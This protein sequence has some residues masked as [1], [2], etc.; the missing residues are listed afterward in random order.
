MIASVE[1]FFSVLAMGSFFL[2]LLNFIA[3]GTDDIIGLGL[4][5]SARSSVSQNECKRMHGHASDACDFIH[6][7]IVS[8]GPLFYCPYESFL[9]VDVELKFFSRTCWVANNVYW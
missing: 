1:T 8:F 3:Y 7:M 6:K 9:R 5:P 2:S 4:C